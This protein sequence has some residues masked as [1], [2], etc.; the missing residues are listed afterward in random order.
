MH[1]YLHA[2][3]HCQLHY[4]IKISYFIACYTKDNTSI[5]INSE[6]AL[7]KLVRLRPAKIPRCNTIK[8]EICELQHI[9]LQISWLI[10]RNVKILVIRK[11][12]KYS[13]AETVSIHLWNIIAFKSLLK[14]ILIFFYLIVIFKLYLHIFG[15]IVCCYFLYSH[16]LRRSKS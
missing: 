7:I 9:D 13:N 6:Q 8:F 2:L 15:D 1:S 5:I 11:R 12:K 3:V 10:S 16:I 4:A 14:T